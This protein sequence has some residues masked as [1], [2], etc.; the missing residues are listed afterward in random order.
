ML[1][2]PTSYYFTLGLKSASNEKVKLTVVDV[3]GRAVEQRSDVPANSN[4]QIG[5]SY[6]PGIY[7]A[8]LIQG[9]E[10]IILKLIKEGK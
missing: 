10:T 3:S 1:P 4:L 8:Q 2:N 7:F 5:N 9:K 6:H